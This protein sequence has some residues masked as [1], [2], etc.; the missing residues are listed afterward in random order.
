MLF[1]SRA[2]HL[3]L[4]A[5]ASLNSVTGVREVE[6]RKS[7]LI[8]R[9]EHAL[10]FPAH[11][12]GLNCPPYTRPWGVFCEGR[13]GYTEKYYLSCKP[14]RPPAMMRTGRTRARLGSPALRIIRQPGYCPQGFKCFPHDGT[15]AWRP[16]NAGGSRDER[17]FA[18]VECILKGVVD[19]WR[20][21]QMEALERQ[22]SRP[23]V[24]SIEIPAVA[25]AATVTAVAALTTEVAEEGPRTA[26][27]ITIVSIDE[28]GLIE[29][30]EASESTT[31]ER[32][33]EWA[34]NWQLGSS[35]EAGQSSDAAGDR[36]P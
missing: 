25:A 26:P 33:R 28:L 35:A 23:N 31:M 16:S 5:A 1:T 6:P 27:A 2:K 19:Q 10:R 21:L 32:Y 14:R 30:V 3:I 8:V 7:M 17:S 13:R 18:E 34:R 20:Q 15:D 29:P 12:H 4:Q 11:H 24:Q 36:S 9:P 22:L